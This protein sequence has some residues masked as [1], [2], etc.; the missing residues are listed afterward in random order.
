MLTSSDLSHFKAPSIRPCR[1]SQEGCSPFSHPTFGTFGG[2]D[3]RSVLK[4]SGRLLDCSYLLTLHS[5]GGT[6][7]LSFVFES[8]SFIFCKSV[9]LL[10][11]HLEFEPVFIY[12]TRSS[13][14][15]DMDWG[16]FSFDSFFNCG[17]SSWGT[18]RFSFTVKSF[19]VFDN[20]DLKFL[21]DVT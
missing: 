11:K 10:R 3:I 13:G 5:S 21:F 15:G 1:S 4:T 20:P 12:K 18:E 2:N 9:D 19:S 14:L 8:L 17:Y 7:L 16:R 6:D